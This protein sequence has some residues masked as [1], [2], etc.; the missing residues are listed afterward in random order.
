MELAN[1]FV[2]ETPESQPYDRTPWLFFLWG[3]GYEFD[4][5]QNW[6][7]IEELAALLAGR[8]DIWYATNG[9]IHDYVEAYRHLNWT[10]QGDAVYNPTAVPV[11]FELER[12]IYVVQPGELL[13]LPTR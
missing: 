10:L 2:N 8:S 4:L 6:S 3:H 11:W 12:E 5:S 1:R 13:T 9:E 7:L